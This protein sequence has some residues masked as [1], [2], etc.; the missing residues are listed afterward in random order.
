MPTCTQY[1][2]WYESALPFLERMGD[3][4]RIFSASCSCLV[5]SLLGESRIDLGDKAREKNQLTLH[6]P[7]PLLLL[8]L[9]RL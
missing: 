8:P 1:T 9:R 2:E 4:V 7:P 3:H 5:R 6:A